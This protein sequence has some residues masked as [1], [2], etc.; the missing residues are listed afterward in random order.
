MFCN[1]IVWKSQQQIPLTSVI[2]HSVLFYSIHRQNLLAS[3]RGL[4]DSSNVVLNYTEFSL[5][6]RIHHMGLFL[7]DD[8]CKG[9]RVCARHS[10]DSSGLCC[11]DSSYTDYLKLS[12]RLF[13][14]RNGMKKSPAYV[15]VCETVTVAHEAWGGSTSVLPSLHSAYVFALCF[16]FFIMACMCVQPFGFFSRAF[17]LLVC[18]SSCFFCTKHIFF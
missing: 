11:W 12:S 5:L 8:V 10:L 6:M 4:P 9:E 15:R 16:S 17:F 3:Q 2:L 7:R 14:R 13:L 1:H 18:S